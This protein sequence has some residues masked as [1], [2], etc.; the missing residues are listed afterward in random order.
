MRVV[1]L[2]GYGVFGSRLAEL[3]MR[4]G[5]DVL[6]AGRHL[7]KLAALAARLRCKHVVLDHRNDPQAL[8]GA[9]PDVVIDAAGPVQA[10]ESD[11]YLI[12]RLCLDHGADYLDLSDDAKFTQGIA[13]L[14][15]RARSCGRRLLS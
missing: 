10:Y 1:V 4:D 5:H 11:P 12:P 8:F 6:I 3:L 2:G 14:D 13:M 15:G 7:G 9:S